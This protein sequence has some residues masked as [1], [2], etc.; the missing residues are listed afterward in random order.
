MGAT[1]E[2][3]VWTSGA[4]EADNLALLG[5]ARFNR[6]RRHIVTSRTEHPAVLDACRQLEREGSTVTYLKPDS[7]GIVEP[8][9]VEAALRDETLL[10]SLMHVNNEIGVVQD[11]AAVGRLCRE[12][13]ILLHVDAAQAA[14]KVELNVHRDGIDLLSLTAHK[15][16]GPKGIGALC[17]RRS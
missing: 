11:V 8:A 9:Q 6:E 7:T 5:V 2:Q 1:P 16:H 10:V 4:T 13:G 12:R 17:V 15:I 14:G 3:I